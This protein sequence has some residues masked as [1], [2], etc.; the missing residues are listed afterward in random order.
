VIRPT[1]L[2][3]VVLQS[4]PSGADIVDDRSGR[5]GVTPYELVLPAG[6]ERQVRFEKSGYLPT[7]RQVLALG[8]TT[9]AVRLDPEPLTPRA[10]PRSAARLD[11]GAT[12][13]PFEGAR[14]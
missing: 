10:R 2:V 4:V 12:I 3:T 14:R 7:S 6:G 9:I 13:D 1:S 11:D 8:D 5:L